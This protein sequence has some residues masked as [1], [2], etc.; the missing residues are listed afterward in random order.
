MTDTTLDVLLEAVRHQNIILRMIAEEC[1]NRNEFGI[2]P[3]KF[4]N[5]VNIDT[6]LSETQAKL[7]ALIAKR[8]GPRDDEPREK[9]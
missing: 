8:T 7:D 4:F 1:C 2:D 6:L 9:P 3:V 5:R